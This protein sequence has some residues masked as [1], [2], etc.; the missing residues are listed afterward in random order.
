MSR[1]SVRIALTYAS[2]NNL[3]VLRADIQNVYLQAPPTKKHYIVRGPEF[4]LENIGKKAI[5]VKGHYMVAS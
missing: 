2:L 5:I 3:S 4:E 1:E